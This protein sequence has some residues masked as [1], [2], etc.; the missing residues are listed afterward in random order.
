MPV[1]GR[2]FHVF[3]RFA[4]ANCRCS[5]EFSNKPLEIQLLQKCAGT[6]HQVGT[7]LKHDLSQKFLE[8]PLPTAL[9]NS[10]THLWQ[11]F[12]ENASVRAK[13]QGKGRRGRKRYS[14]TLALTCPS[15]RIHFS[16]QEFT[17]MPGSWRL[18]MFRCIIQQLCTKFDSYINGVQSI[19]I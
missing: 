18:S 12:E 8:S 15:R 2:I 6:L 17:Y 5:K 1:V 9:N 3:P 4:N 19:G 10:A 11:E 7:L 16:P 14:F 13:R